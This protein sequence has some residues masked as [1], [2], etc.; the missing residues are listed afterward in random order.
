[1]QAWVS[2]QYVLVGTKCNKLLCVDAATLHVHNIP[3]P[4]K[5]AHRHWLLG[6]NATHSG[7][8]IHA[9]DVSPDGSMLA[10]SIAYPSDCQI[11]HIQHHNGAP[12]TFTATHSLMVCPVFSAHWI[13]AWLSQLSSL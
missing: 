8:G 11:F 10:V 4:P 3:L 6:I 12:P 5:P 2:D 1:M 7:C 13:P 9:I